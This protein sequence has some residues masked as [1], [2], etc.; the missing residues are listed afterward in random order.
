MNLSACLT[1]ALKCGASNE[2]YISF[3]VFTRCWGSDGLLG[4]YTMQDNKVVN[5]FDGPQSSNFP[6]SATHF[7]LPHMSS[8]TWTKFSHP[9]N[10]GSALL[11]NVR[12]NLLFYIVWEPR[13]P[14]FNKVLL[15]INS[16]LFRCFHIYIYYVELFFFL[17][18]KTA[19]FKLYI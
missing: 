18:F 16:L 14:S 5:S 11:Q 15:R 7:L 12:T 1:A 3:Q 4:S 8:S 19:I 6:V 13:R 2:V 17:F 9:D 10:V